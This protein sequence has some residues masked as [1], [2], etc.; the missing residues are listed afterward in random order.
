MRKI[1]ILDEEGLGS[2]Q[3]GFE[4]LSELGQVERYRNTASSDIVAR[5]GQNEIVLTNKAVIDEGVM[6][7]CPG[8]KYIGVLSTRYNVVDVQAATKRGI[9]VTNIPAYSTYAVVQHSLA[10]LLEVCNH[11]H[12]HNQAVKEGKWENSPIYCFWEKPLTELYGKKMGI[13]GLGRIGQGLAKNGAGAW[14]GDAG[15]HAHEKRFA[16]SAG[17][18]A[19]RIIEKA[20]CWHVAPRSRRQR[21][22]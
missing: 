3:L 8:I 1:V 4:A 13:I 6:D 15:I 18:F 2:E 12:L 11:V 14:D 17:N 16:W 21:R 7:A 20:M 10:L 22:A 9:V 5:I 19:A